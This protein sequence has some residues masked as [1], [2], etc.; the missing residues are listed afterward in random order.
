[1]KKW[2]ILII[3]LLLLISY[4]IFEVSKIKVQIDLV[5]F[6]VSPYNTY[7]DFNRSISLLG[8][9][10][11][12]SI[13]QD[14]MGLSDRTK[15]SF[16]L[17]FVDPI[18]ENSSEYYWYLQDDKYLS[19]DI[20]LN[21]SLSLEKFNVLESPITN[22]NIDKYHFDFP[23][24]TYSYKIF[25]FN[26]YDKSNLSSQITIFAESEQN[27][28]EFINGLQE[29]DILYVLNDSFEYQDSFW[30]T[31]RFIFSKDS[32]TPLIF[33]LFIIVIFLSLYQDRRNL[34]IKL[35]NGYSKTQYILEK[36]KN[37]LWVQTI[38]F[39]CSF[40]AYYLFSYYFNFKHLYLMLSYYIP[41]I[42]VINLVVIVLVS[43][44]VYSFT[45]INQTTYV[46]GMS[47]KAFTSYIVSISKFTIVV[48]ICMSLIPSI[49]N[50][51]YSVSLYKHLSEQT[52]K[53]ANIYTIDTRGD[54]SITII[55][56]SDEI[57]ESLKEFDNIIYQNHFTGGESEESS[58]VV[59]I[60]DN[61][62]KRHPI[63]DENK[64]SIDPDK[65]NVVYT[66]AHNVEGIER[67]KQFPGF[68][69][70]SEENCLDIET[71]ILDDEAT[72]TL[73]SM[74]PF[75]DDELISQDFI[76]VPR[77]KDFFILELFFV[78]E[79]NEQIEEV[80]N[81]LKDVVDIE[82][83]NFVKITNNWAEDLDIYKNS[84]I[85][86]AIT[87]LNYL[88]IILILS[89]IYY[90]IKFDKVRKE[91]SIYWVNGISKFKYFYLEYIYQI[92]LSG[93]VIML[94]KRILY[95]ELSIV[96]MLIIFLIYILIDTVSLF[97]F[98]HLFYTQLQKNIK[99]QI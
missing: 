99:E 61:Y 36:I 74:N 47:P 20:G 73:Y 28:D 66:K 13:K 30:D 92:I 94:I 80:R 83:I 97:I 7:Q 3:I 67:L 72:L 23:L 40:L 24:D 55:E 91:F 2:K 96:L 26:L 93:I 64:N 33:G 53:Y 98:R 87:I 89:I 18:Q 27:I 46:Q 59:S 52:I 1:M 31:I 14:L 70:E 4:S 5:H 19:R 39:I 45:D 57:I 6:A 85:E 90:Q 8:A 75:M 22:H 78:F 65:I 9:D 44:I 62:I 21:K 25:P 71:I 58:K 50:I 69:C 63:L 86:D 56:K 95:P 77:S 34:S 37:I 49:N 84:I 29:K 32:F 11:T 10:D 60:N 51:I 42:L 35:V 38:T 43:I 88:V 41:V 48:L 12:E 17:T 16:T 79:N 68:L 82:S 15:A 76:L 81:Q 54:Y